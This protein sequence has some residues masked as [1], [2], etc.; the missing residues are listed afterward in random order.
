VSCAAEEAQDLL[1][2]FP[3]ILSARGDARAPASAV[4]VDNL[5]LA[6][7]FAGLS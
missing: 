7:R 2:Y 5:R 3:D 4:A 1:H 6:L